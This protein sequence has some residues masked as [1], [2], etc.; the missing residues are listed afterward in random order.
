MQ[1]LPDKNGK[2]PV[3]FAW[4]TL[5]DFSMTAVAT[6]GF[7][8]LERVCKAVLP[9]FFVNIINPKMTESKEV[10]LEKMASATYKLLFYVFSTIWVLRLSIGQRWN[11]V[12]MGGL[13]A[14]D[15]FLI[16]S[17]WATR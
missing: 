6:V 3:G 5:A 9:Q 11:P 4:T 7:M 13:A 17:D 10:K 15:E 14:P 2:F 16:F 12:A 8:L 1:A